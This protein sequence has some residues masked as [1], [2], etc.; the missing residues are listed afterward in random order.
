MLGRKQLGLVL[1]GILVL[2]VSLISLEMFGEEAPVRGGTLRC[3]FEGDAIGLDPHIA[4]AQASENFFCLVYSSL[5]TYDYD[6]VLKPALAESWSVSDDGLT[7]TFNLR[8]GVKFH[9]GRELT[10]E[11][12]K[13]SIERIV[14]LGSS[15]SSRFSTVKEMRTPSRYVF[16]IVLERIHAPFLWYVASY[17][18]AIVP[19]EVVEEHG[20]LQS[21]MVGT[22]PFKMVEYKPGESMRLVRNEDYFVEGQPYLDEILISIIPDAVTRIT[23]L[24]TGAVDWAVW[25]DPTVLRILEGNVGIKTMQQ[26]TTD[27]YTLWVNCKSGTPLDDVRVRQAITVALDRQAIIDLALVGSGEPSGPLAPGMVEYALPISELPFYKDAPNIAMAKD[28][29]AAA[30]YATGFD[31]TIDT[32][33]EYPLQV[34]A[35]EV[36]QEQL[37]E[38][39]INVRLNVVEWGVLIDYWVKREFD[40]ISILI[41]GANDPSFYFYDRFHSTSSGNASQYENPVMDALTEAGL[42]IVAPAE[43][44][45]VY[46]ELQGF[47]AEEGPIIFIATG[48]E[49]YG[50][51][52]YVM[53]FHGTPDAKRF[54]LADVWLAEH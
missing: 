28:L 25:I 26:M 8:Q 20:D 43:R 30:G 48:T 32:S 41:A 23:A 17:W 49:E 35:A 24:R 3:A 16:E 27:R 51:R 29:L 10:S 19:K 50:M 54:Y 52:D 31:L 12:C 13:Y 33:P 15:W 47:T 11:D 37:R 2:L 5:L 7:Y 45:V 46:D 36:V 38:I 14:Q 1:V 4:T 44:K 42:A 34:K 22:G 21:V 39:G 6:L 18:A 53:G 9:N 40:M